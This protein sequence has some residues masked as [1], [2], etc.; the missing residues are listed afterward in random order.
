M[1]YQFTACQMWHAIISIRSQDVS[2]LSPSPPT[3]LPDPLTSTPYC[4]VVKS[5][6]VGE[7]DFQVWILS[8]WGKSNLRRKKWKK[9][10]VVKSSCLHL[11]PA[12]NGILANPQPHFLI[13]TP[14]SSALNLAIFKYRLAYRA[15]TLQFACVG[16]H[17]PSEYKIQ[18]CLLILSQN[19]Q[20]GCA[21][22]DHMK[23]ILYSNVVL[24][25]NSLD[26]AYSFCWNK[27]YKIN[28]RIPVSRFTWYF[29]FKYQQTPNLNGTVQVLVN[30]L[31]SLS[32]YIIG[33]LLF[34]TEFV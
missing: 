22:A 16:L 20:Q 33:S 21:S 34:S 13:S 19:E 6:G 25:C 12:V 28:R 11:T 30:L 14:L 9:E 3:W 24:L 15:L 27:T 29:G 5:G 2:F 1:S 10:A 17:F 4:T 8:I 26:S 32:K 18:T 23:N 7:F 31:G